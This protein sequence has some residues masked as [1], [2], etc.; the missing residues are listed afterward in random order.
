MEVYCDRC[1]DRMPMKRVR[2][3][4]TGRLLAF[5]FLLMTVVSLLVIESWIL[6]VICLGLALV[7]Y[8]A[9]TNYW[10]CETCGGLTERP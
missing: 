2:R 7:L 5:A 6:G 9:G 8:M 1:E 3:P 4:K 10:E